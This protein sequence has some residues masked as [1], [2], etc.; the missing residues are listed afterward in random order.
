LI[1]LFESFRLPENRLMNRRVWVCIGLI[2]WSELLAGRARAQV[3]SIP[4]SSSAGVSIAAKSALDATAYRSQIQQFVDGEMDALTGEDPIAQKA[5][6]E[7]LISEC[8]PGSM[9]SY[10]DNYAQVIDSSAT[11]VLA[12]NPSLRVRLNVAVLVH[13]IAEVVRSTRSVA[14]ENSVLV[15]INDPSESI[16][17]I[18]MEAAKPVIASVVAHPQTAPSD[19]L[20]NAILPAVKSHEKSGYIAAE[21]Y[22]SLIPDDTLPATDLAQIDP[23]VLGPILDI[24]NYR[25]SLYTTSIP[26]NPSAETSVPTFLYRSYTDAPLALQ[27]RIVQSLVDLISV[28]GQQAPAAPK[29]DL[30][31]IIRTLNYAAGALTAH[32]PNLSTSLDF[33][34]HLDKST[35]APVIAQK[36]ASV[37]GMLQPQ[38]TFL[39]PPPAVTPATAPTTKPE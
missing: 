1:P 5:A 34:T 12:R 38:F 22:R 11:Q 10:L 39:Q 24:L 2:V 18:G 29:D 8:T 31:E 36:T 25:I 17:L 13:E 26:D 23:I 30:D 19:K 32:N 9:P 33:I 15:L 14:L 20:L 3:P 21:A 37:F 35:P 4:D 28:A 16:A 6:R 27:Q 7:K